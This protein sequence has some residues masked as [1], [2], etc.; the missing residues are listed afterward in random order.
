MYLNG[1][2]STTFDIDFLI[3]PITGN[4]ALSPNTFTVQDVASMGSNCC[5]NDMNVMR[6]EIIIKKIGT[7]GMASSCS[8]KMA[9]KK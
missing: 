7:L 5:N 3:E 4:G 6:R 1:D 8:A 2:G 9:P